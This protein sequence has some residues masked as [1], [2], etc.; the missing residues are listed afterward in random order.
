M[1]N[2]DNTDYVLKIWI[3]ENFQYKKIIDKEKI[4]PVI[5]YNSCV[6]WK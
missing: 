6:S 2:V 5:F 4:T 3:R 1:N